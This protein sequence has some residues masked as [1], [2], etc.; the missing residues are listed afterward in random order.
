MEKS[1]KINHYRQKLRQL[2][3]EV[4]SW[5]EEWK[6]ISEYML[7]KRGMYLTSDTEK[8]AD[9]GKKK[10]QK[11]INGI[12]KKSLL[13]ISA[14]LQSG[15]T[16][17]S[18]PWFTLGIA[19]DDLMEISEVREWLDLV[20][21]EMMQVF[22][23]SNFYS[24]I[25]STYLELAAF[26][27]A[28][29][30][31]ESDD[32]TVIRCRPYTI[33]EYFLSQDSNLRVNAMYRKFVMTAEQLEDKFGKEKLSETIKS[34]LEL[35]NNGQEEFEIIHVIE[36]NKDI[37]LTKDD[38]SGMAYLS[39]YFESKGK[40]DVFLRKSGYR[41]LPFVAPRWNTTGTGVWGDGVGADALGDVKQLQKL[42][43]LKLMAL[44]KEVNPPLNAP[45]M[46]KN[47][48]VSIIAGDINYYDTAQGNQGVTPTYQV[49]LN[50]RNMSLEIEAVSQRIRQ[51]FYNDLFMS[52]LGEDKRMTATEVNERSNERML[53]IGS[54]IER[55]Q[56]EMLDVII[57]R[58]FDIMLTQGLLPEPPADLQGKDI[59]V[60]Y[61]SMLAQAQKSVGISSISQVAQF[62]GMLAQI[63]PQVADK[64]D[65]DQAVEE[66]ADAIGIPEKIV[67]S[68][69]KVTALRK[70][71][72]EQQAAQQQQMLQAQ[73]AAQSPQQMQQGAA[74]AKDLSETQ[75]GN[76]TALDALLRSR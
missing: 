65:F 23:K 73:M 27:T 4:E 57:D 30:L 60:E 39:C 37:D 41:S 34:C 2:E 43:Q 59:K 16:S 18:R 63:N 55:I 54:V 40:S 11:I 36:P 72:A 38:S 24:A 28:N 74:A 67:I 52:I 45:V 61:I 3:E 25:H 44:E 49:Q 14:G 19:D 13:T 70:Q 20:R 1:T 58:T 10:H 69:D 47:S 48:G 75:T 46:L 17:P 62:V 12:A 8:N 6:E 56:S 71:R 7:P 66:Y 42:E 31:I 33:G 26:G 21:K 5:K 22:M 53:L 35:G 64:F 51:A 76:G 29:L 50:L 15:M 9:H 32:E 68:D